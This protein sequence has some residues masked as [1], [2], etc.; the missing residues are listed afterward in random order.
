MGEAARPYHHGDLWRALLEAA[1]TILEREGT[2]RLTLRAVAREAG[3]SHAAPAHHFGD[4]TGLLSELAAIGYARFRDRLAAARD[5]APT[6]ALHALGVA[7]VAFART[8]PGL[9]TL[10]FRSDRID[11]QRPSLCAAAD[12][13]WEVLGRGV[14][15]A[16]AV[17]GAPLD[18]LAHRIAPWALAHGLAFLLIDGRLDPQLA[19][20]PQGA[21]DM[22]ALL[23]ATLRALVL[24]HA[25]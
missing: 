22:D 20:L 25:R 12:S 1:E 17:P 14:A 23:R 10:M 19:A 11:M 9:F 24:R 6:D 13:A 7:Y 3:V 15:A 16:Q 4:L 18:D 21:R 8:H 2:G 5:A